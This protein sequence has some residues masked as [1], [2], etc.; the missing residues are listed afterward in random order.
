[1]KSNFKVDPAITF[2]HMHTEEQS[3]T[4]SNHKINSTVFLFVMEMITIGALLGFMI[5]LMN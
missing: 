1:M 2:D 3:N 5:L 4:T